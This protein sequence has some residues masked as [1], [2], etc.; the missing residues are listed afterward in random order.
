MIFTSKCESIDARQLPRNSQ[1]P[2][3]MGINNTCNIDQM[4]REFMLIRSAGRNPVVCSPESFQ[5][6]HVAKLSFGH[7]GVSAPLEDTVVS[8][9][10]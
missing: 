7:Y 5:S 6:I 3:Y 9:F 2:F 10:G 4:L 1:L 8:K